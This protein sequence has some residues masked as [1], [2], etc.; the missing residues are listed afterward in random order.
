MELEYTP[1]QPK[2]QAPK[3]SEYILVEDVTGKPPPP[4]GIQTLKAYAEVLDPK[5]KEK[6]QLIV[7]FKVPYPPKSGCKKCYGRGYVGIQHVG[8]QP[9]ILYCKKCYPML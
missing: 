6:K 4:R 1:Q 9:G 7:P 5:T 2:Q 3:S 8:K